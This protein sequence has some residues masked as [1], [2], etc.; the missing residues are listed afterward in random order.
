MPSKHYR[1]QARWRI[2]AGTCRATHDTG[3]IVAFDGPPGQGGPGQPVNDRTIAAALAP[4]HGPHNVGPM[5]A[6]LLREAQ[7]LYNAPPKEGTHG[8]HA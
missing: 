7:Q 2:D 5:I 8:P 1:W 6:R 3:L 4:H